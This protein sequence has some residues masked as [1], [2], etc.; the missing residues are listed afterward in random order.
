MCEG[1]RKSLKG[2]RSYAQAALRDRE[3]ELTISMDE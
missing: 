3:G 1:K 2:V